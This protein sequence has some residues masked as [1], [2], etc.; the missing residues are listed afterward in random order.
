MNTVRRSFYSAGPISRSRSLTNSLELA[1]RIAGRN[2]SYAKKNKRQ[3]LFDLKSPD[4]NSSFLLSQL[5]GSPGSTKKTPGKKLTLS[6]ALQSPSQ[7]TRSKTPSKTMSSQKALFKDKSP[8]RSIKKLSFTPVKTETNVSVPDSPCMNTR[9]HTPSKINCT[10]PKSPS[11]SSHFLQSPS[12]NTRSK[13][14]PTRHS[15]KAK[16]FV[17]SPESKQKTTN[18]NISTNLRKGLDSLSSSTKAFNSS[19]AGLTV[20][21]S[22]DKVN[23]M[24]DNLEKTPSPTKKPV[25]KTPG[26][27]DSWPR[28]KKWTKIKYEESPKVIQRRKEI[29]TEYCESV[30]SSHSNT[31]SSDDD[32]VVIRVTDKLDSD[33]KMPYL[34]EIDSSSMKTHSLSSKRSLALSPDGCLESPAKRKCFS[35]SKSNRSTPLYTGMTNDKDE[36]EPKLKISRKRTSNFSPDN[37]VFSPGK[38]LKSSSQGSGSPKKGLSLHSHLLTRNFSNL[39]DGM[40]SSQGFDINSRSSQGSSLSQDILS[41]ADNDSASVDEVFSSPTRKSRNSVL[42]QSNAEKNNSDLGICRTESPVFGSSKKDKL[43]SRLKSQDFNVGK[44]CDENLAAITSPCAKMLQAEDDNSTVSPS[45]RK[46][47]PS[48][49]AKSLCHLISSPLLNSSTVKENKDQNSPKIDQ[50]SINIRRQ[51]MSGRIRRSLI[52]N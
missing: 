28:K 33:D 16:L 48:V 32:E 37:S 5:M 27:L 22:K 36:I 41:I 38:R 52:Q 3:S 25:I 44:N 51:K 49:S 13:F 39:S 1:D 20:N 50:D 2:T 15:V 47:S 6:Q 26:S 40:M 18:N 35:P 21:K 7:N 4:R 30:K 42:S 31:S 17:V 14:T 43:Q 10:P 46:Y 12:Q 9:S 29:K 19:N 23:H 45:A 24:G 34:N 8:K 11:T